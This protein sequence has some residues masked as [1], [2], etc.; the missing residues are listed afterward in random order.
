MKLKGYIFSRFFFG[1]RVPQNVQNIVIRDYCK[2]KQINFLMSATEYSFKGSSLILLELIKRILNFDGLIF[3]SLFQLPDDLTLRKKIYKKIIDNKKQIHFALENIVGKKKSDFDFIERIFLIKKNSLNKDKS[4]NLGKQKKYITKNHEKTKR[5]YLE[6]MFNNKI[7][8]MKRA[9]K[10]SFDYWDGDRKF[11]YGGY[12]YI[13]NYHRELAKKLINDYKLN[14][15]SKVL[16]IGCGK[17]F[18]LYE[19]KKILKNIKL[20]GL[21]ISSYAIRKSKKEVKKYLKTHDINYGLKKF[22]TNSFDLIFS[23]NTLH[24]IKLKNI[25]FCLKEIER[26]G[27]EKFICVESY[28]NEKQQFNL[29]CWALTAETI[30]GVDDWKWLFLENGY[31]GEYE[32]IFFN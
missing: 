21:D 25:P 17:G 16:D 10:Y 31:T 7:I 27:K 1:E 2:K 23:I 28:K 13:P 8:C 24:N 3:Y 19:I 9:K 11:G 5:N 12:K 4:K 30:I 20:V 26:V 6:R 15:N 14:S 18:L 22:N 32:F 29:Q